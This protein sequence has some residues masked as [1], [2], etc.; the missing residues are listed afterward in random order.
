MTLPNF[1]YIGASKAGSTWI[2]HALQAHPEVFVP[3]AK[4]VCFFTH[5]YDRGL[6]WYARF[7]RRAGEQHRAVGELT[8]S[9]LIHETALQRISQDLPCVRLLVSL[10]NPVERAW[11]AYLFFRRNNQIRP[12]FRQAVEQDVRFVGVT[13]HYRRHLAAVDRH[14]GGHP[15]GLFLF[16]DLKRD[17]AGFARQIYG[18]L[19]VGTDFECPAVKRNPLPASEYRVPWLAAC[20]KHASRGMRRMGFANF[21]GRV[22]TN[23][24]VLR[25]LYRPLRGSGRDVMPAEDWEYMAELYRADIEYVA[26][27]TGRDLSHWYKYPSCK[28]TNG[29]DR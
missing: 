26:D 16:D 29:D 3:A 9:Y 27:R 2:F 15:L 13:G 14:V 10:R 12:G 8:V 6:E 20:V 21:I 1:L 22:K 7:F 11:S 5:S 25:T 18:F 28:E 23:S 24:L 4:D 19:G 17:P